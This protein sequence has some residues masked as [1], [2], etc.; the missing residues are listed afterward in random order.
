M[1]KCKLQW[2]GQE[3]H[4]QG[5]EG[6]QQAMGGGALPARGQYIQRP[7]CLQ[8]LR[9]RKT[10]NGT[11]VELLRDDWKKKKKKESGESWTPDH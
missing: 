6:K 3:A 9:T 10:S 8:C 4:L 1:M 7:M 5:I 2:V 11:R